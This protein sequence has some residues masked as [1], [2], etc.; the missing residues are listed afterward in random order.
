[1]QYVASLA[2]AWRSPPLA[3]TLAA[4]ACRTATLADVTAACRPHRSATGEAGWNRLAADLGAVYRGCPDASRPL[5]G[6]WS[7]AEEGG[8]AVEPGER[9]F[10]DVA[11]PT[12]EILTHQNH[13]HA[14]AVVVEGVAGLLNRRDDVLMHLLGKP[15]RVANEP[16]KV[17]EGF[18]FVYLG[19]V[20][21]AG[22]GVA[23]GSEAR[24]DVHIDPHEVE[25]ETHKD[26][27]LNQILR[28]SVAVEGQDDGPLR[29]AVPA[30]F[31]RRHDCCSHVSI[32]SGTGNWRI[33]LT[34]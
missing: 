18:V 14:L 9:A 24:I 6:L 33:Q 31:V 20:L 19:Q 8:L 17:L 2:V 30:R 4:A 28:R 27:V 26:L 32:L 15:T 34:G 11:V 23:H 16:T 10:H 29:G 5:V 1:M 21:D 7:D 13:L 25:T 22:S 3:M 12:E